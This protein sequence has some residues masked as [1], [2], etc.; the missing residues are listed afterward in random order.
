MHVNLYTIVV[1]VLFS[2]IPMLDPL[3]YALDFDTFII[4]GTKWDYPHGALPARAARQSPRKR[5]SL[6]AASKSNTR[7][8]YLGNFSKPSTGLRPDASPSQGVGKDDQRRNPGKS[9]M[10]KGSSV[11]AALQSTAAIREDD[12]DSRCPT[13]QAE[14]YITIQD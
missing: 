12:D 10:P 3:C 4:R 1:S 2:I 5:C 13:S 14:P 11:Q 9:H 6:P 8:G 7:A